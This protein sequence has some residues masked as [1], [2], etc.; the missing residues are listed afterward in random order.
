[1]NRSRDSEVEEMHPAAHPTLGCLE[2]TF[3]GSKH[4]FQRCSE[5]GDSMTSWNCPQPT[6]CTGWRSLCP[7][8]AYRKPALTRH[9]PSKT[10]PSTGCTHYM[11]PRKSG[12]RAP[13]TKNSTH[14]GAIEL[15]SLTLRRL[16]HSDVSTTVSK[17][18]KTSGH[19]RICV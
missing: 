5:E 2:A 8:P 16:R 12:H 14:R 7:S 17:L 4:V 19:V 11:T 10:M 3:A 1:M 9:K 13:V 18:S 6:M 15:R